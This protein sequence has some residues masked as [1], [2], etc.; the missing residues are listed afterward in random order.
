[1]SVRRRALGVSEETFARYVAPEL[2]WVRRGAV[3]LVS[4]A[5]LEAWLDRSAERTIDEEDA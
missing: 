3:K 1:V 2:R 4:V 5:E